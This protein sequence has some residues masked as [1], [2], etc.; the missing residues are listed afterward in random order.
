MY[1]SGSTGKPKGVQIEHAA[2]TAYCFADIDVY[3]VTPTDRTLQFSTLNFDIAI[4][5]IFPPLLT[6]GCVVVR[7]LRHSNGHNELSDIVDRYH[8]TAIHLATAYWHEWVDLMVATGDRI[9]ATIRLMVVTGE[10]VSVEHYRRWQSICDHNVLWCNAYGP[11][12]ATVSATVFI[13]DDSFDA[14]N[15]PI[16]NP[17]KR[18]NAFI[19]NDKLQEISEGETGQLFIG[20]PAL[21]RGYL[22]RPDLTDQAFINVKLSSGE[23]QRLYRTGDLAR[24]LPNNEIEFCGR[25]DHQ[26]KLGTYRIEPG[27]IEAALEQH[28][29]VLE[30]LVS[31][32][33]INGKKF[34]IAYVTTDIEENTA[35]ILANFLRDRLP[36]YMIPTRYV[37]LDSFPK[38]INGKIDRKALPNAN[39]SVV[40]R[41]SDYIAPRN[42]LETQLVEVFQDVLNVSDIGIH[43]DFFLMGGSSLLV[44]QVITQLSTQLD[45]ELPVRDFFANPTVATAA[46]HIHQLQNFNDVIEDDS[47]IIALRSR[48]P[49]IHTDYF[50]SCEHRLFSVRYEPQTESRNHAVLICHAY[51]HEYSRAYRNLQQF[52]VQL[53]QAG[54]DVMRFDFSSTGNSE[55]NCELATSDRFRKNIVDAS[56]FFRKQINHDHLS[57]MGIRMG[58]TLAAL[59]NAENIDKLVLWDPI[60]DGRQ[61][62]QL[63]EKLHNNALTSLTRFTCQRERGD[64]DQLYGH[65]MSQEKRNS[66]AK[67]QLQ[68]HKPSY[69][70]M[71]ITSAGYKETEP[72]LNDLCHDWNIQQ[73]SDQIQWHDLQFTESAFSSPNIYS[74]M[75][76]FLSSNQ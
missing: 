53:C 31:Y 27:E 58:A 52:S 70:Q 44:T 55:G 18:Y 20:G 13:P 64:I 26:I 25:T 34:L 46:K 6:G 43:D 5:E 65:Q 17:L 66:F 30:S 71:I 54:F 33:E 24:W 11:T 69:K 4:E 14:P 45:F 61:F 38:T 3:Q 37:F 23:Q 19:L 28:T 49:I 1:T 39:T 36:A 16:G 56:E 73:T 48:L 2:L 32:D 59:N 57:I 15:M 72:G 9:P 68:H 51:G 35:A 50:Q 75:L 12:E 47:D 29:C 74:A 7:P 42:E 76:E 62:L 40:A 8:V 60:V 21:A 63:L 41:E 67:L 22:N 10:K